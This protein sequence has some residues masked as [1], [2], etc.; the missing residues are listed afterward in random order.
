MYTLK[1]CHPNIAIVNQAVAELSDRKVK[2]ATEFYRFRAY[3]IRRLI[4][5]GE[6][7]H[8][9]NVLADSCHTGTYAAAC[10]WCVAGAMLERG[11]LEGFYAFKKA[12]I[13]YMEDRRI[14]TKYKVGEENAITFMK[15]QTTDAYAAAKATVNRVQCKPIIAAYRAACAVTL[16]QTNGDASH[17]ADLVEELI[18]NV[19][20]I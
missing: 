8:A 16:S 13:A 3:E 11:S 4:A 20:T 17:R 9:V 1:E 7:R 10:V 14:I 12:I 2:P 15:G 5:A 18:D 6:Y 19:I